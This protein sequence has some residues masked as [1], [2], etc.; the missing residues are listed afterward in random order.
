MPIKLRKLLTLPIAAF[1]AFAA[2]PHQEAEAGQ[3]LEVQ[4]RALQNL[5]PKKLTRGDREFN[6]HGPKVY[7]KVK[8][9]VS[10][11]KRGIDAVVRFKAS[12]TGGDRSTVD[13]TFWPMRVWTAPSGKKVEQIL[14]RTS[15]TMSFTCNKPAGFQFLAPGEDFR[16]FAKAVMEIVDM[17]IKA[18]KAM[19][20]RDNDTPEVREYKAFATRARA[21]LAGM[22]FQGNHVFSEV[23][24][25]PGGPVA[26]FSFVGD[27]GGD[28][29]SKDRNGKDDTRIVRIDF[30]KVQVKLK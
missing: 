11:D 21:G 30:S 27:T 2:A 18:E 24:D 26:L 22:T 28:D 29:I 13:E 15:S 8:L 12:E 1:I 10:K 4:P 5:V 6:G 19:S 25:T 3:T 14:G 16:D 20:D 17:V 9:Q 7:M 23:E